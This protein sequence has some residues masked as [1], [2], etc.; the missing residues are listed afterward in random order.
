MLKKISFTLISVFFLS[1]CSVQQFLG[2]ESANNEKLSR[3]STNNCDFTNINSLEFDEE[4]LKSVK[5]ELYNG[6]FYGYQMFLC[7]NYKNSIKAFDLVE[8]AHKN[9]DET[10]IALQVGKELLKMLLNDN[11]LDYTGKNYEKMLVNTY[12]AMDYLALGDF[13]SAGVEINRALDRQKRNKEYYEGKINSLLNSS[14]FSP[15]EKDEVMQIASSVKIPYYEAYKDYS[16]PFVSYFASLFYILDDRPSLAINLLQE[17]YT[18][19]KNISVFQDHALVINNFNYKKIPNKIRKNIEKSKNDKY[20]WLIYENGK[21]RAFGEMNLSIPIIFYQKDAENV[22]YALYLKPTSDNNHLVITSV[23]FSIPILKYSS[24]SYMFLYA[25]NKKTS[26]IS[27]MDNIVT[28][29]YQAALPREIAKSFLSTVGKTL[30]SVKANKKN[31]LAGASVD[32][33]NNLLN[34]SDTR[35][36]VGLPKNYQVARIANNGKLVVKS[37]E[38][39]EILNT[40]LDTNKHYVILVKSPNYG[41]FY[42][43]ILKGR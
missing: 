1:A 41:I 25:N 7:K 2:Y 31:L 11:I 5:D 16:N 20:I 6:T 39:V 4:G 33:V 30:A 42:T 24:D 32:L 28:A 37:P 40:E 29:E 15:K 27:N 14:S 36:F 18:Q 26:Q 3:I 35:H 9:N 19:E 8:N 34:H 12:K 10:N 13:D 22:E 17:V 21:T 38:G 23:V 43:H